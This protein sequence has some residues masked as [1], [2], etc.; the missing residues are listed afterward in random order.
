MPG[1]VS[2]DEAYF[3]LMLIYESFGTPVRFPSI[4]VVRHK[5]NTKPY[6]KYEDFINFIEPYY[7]NPD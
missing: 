3:H 6:I 7:I 5:F 2:T 4:P 1:Y